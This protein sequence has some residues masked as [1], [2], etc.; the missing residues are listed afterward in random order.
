[1]KKKH[2]T[3]IIIVAVFVV[4]VV[5]ASFLYGVLI[6]RADI[7]PAISGFHNH[8]HDGDG[9]PDHGP[10]HHH[11]NDQD[12]GDQ[13]DDNGSAEDLGGGQDAD[14]EGYSSDEDPRNG[15]DSGEPEQEAPPEENLG[16]GGIAAPDFM[17]RN[18]DFDEVRLSDY[19]GKPV[20][21]SFWASWCGAC[22]AQMPGFNNV[23]EEV[24]DEVHFMMVNL[25]D[26]ARET[27]A[28]AEGYIEQHGYTFPI[29][30]DTEQ[31]A[32]IAYIIR[33]IPA[34]FFVDSQGYLQA[35]ATGMIDE[36]ALRRGIALIS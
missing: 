31:E 20:I 36:S 22:S 12:D 34:T 1:M 9:I 18:S 21:I 23:F 15:E 6:E 8:D 29:Y 26:G 35:Q 3:L 28:S 32:A 10:G 14:G 17:V 25:T 16:A 7:D 33:S 30:F 27:R 2:V 24:G 11:G 13:G 5:G 4:V 19:L